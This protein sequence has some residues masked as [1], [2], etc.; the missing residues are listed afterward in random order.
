MT[1]LTMMSNAKKQ[2]LHGLVLLIL[3][4]QPVHAGN[5]ST[6]VHL[7]SSFAPYHEIEVPHYVVAYFQAEINFAD[8]RHGPDAVVI[9]LPYG[10]S[11][12]VHKTRFIPREGYEYNDPPL[13]PA[14]VAPGAAIEDMEYYWSGKDLDSGD[15]VTIS[16]FGTIIISAIW[17]NGKKFII[18][19]DGQHDVT[20]LYELRPDGIRPGPIAP[21]PVTINESISLLLLSLWVVLL[22]IAYGKKH[23]ENQLN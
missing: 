23:R 19:H 2:G 5:N 16:V 17:T 11:V 21:I 10:T 9:Q 6:I 4:L 3:M 7:V 8:M 18:N 13:P 22:G 12:T 1:Q 20:L 14:T 15:E